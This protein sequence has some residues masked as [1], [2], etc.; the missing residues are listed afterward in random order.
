M[1]LRVSAQ[2]MTNASWPRGRRCS[3][4]NWWARSARSVVTVVV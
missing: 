1:A 2:L 3:E 4:F